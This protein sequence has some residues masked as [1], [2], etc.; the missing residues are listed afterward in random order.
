[1]E[2]TSR[3]DLFDPAALAALGHFEIVAR[4]IV[5]GFLSGLHRSP[6]KGFSVEFADFRPYQPGDDLRYVDWKIAARVRPLGR[7]AVRGGD[8]PPRHDRPR[9]QPLDGLAGGRRRRPRHQARVRR[10]AHRRARAPAAA[11]ARRRRSHSLRR[12]RPH[13]ASRRAP[14]PGSGAALVAALAEPATAARPISPRRLAR[15][16]ASS[17]GEGWSS[18]SAICS[19]TSTK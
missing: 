9:R 8:E 12:R 2:L 11:P 16:P 18:S 15:P 6:R 14:A 10:A 4:W 3:A 5:D 1:M 19:S 13:P 7:E 17:R